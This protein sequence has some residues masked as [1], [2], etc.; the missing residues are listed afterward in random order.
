MTRET[1]HHNHHTIERDG[2]LFRVPTLP[3]QSQPKKCPSFKNL[4]AA[5]A[6]IDRMVAL[7]R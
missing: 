3:F 7:G 2:L 4:E 1:Y 6:F 5:K